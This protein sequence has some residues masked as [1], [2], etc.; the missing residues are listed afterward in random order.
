MG[1]WIDFDND[2]K[3][4]NTTFM[5]SIQSAFAELWK[6]ETVYCGTQVMPYRLDV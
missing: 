1:R 6:K 4:L 5:Q 3:T 2:Y